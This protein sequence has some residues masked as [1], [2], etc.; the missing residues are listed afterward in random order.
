MLLWYIISIYITRLR[1]SESLKLEQKHAENIKKEN[2]AQ[3]KLFTNISH[4]FRTPL[5]LIISQIET[6]IQNNRF[7]NQTYNKLSIAYHNC[8]QLRELITELLDYRKHEMGHLKLQVCH[9]DIIHFVRENYI[10][11]SDYASKNNI[12]IEFNTD[13]ESLDLW[14]DPKHFQKVINNLLFNAIKSTGNGGKISIEVK[15]DNKNA[16]ISISDNGKG[17][18]AKDIDKIFDI[19]YQV[20]DSNSSIPGTTGSGIGLAF[21]KTIID[22]HHGNIKV[23]SK[24][25]EGSTFSIILPLGKA[26][27]SKSE[28]IFSQPT[29]YS[30]PVFNSPTPIIQSDE[31]ESTT[32]IAEIS[33]KLQSKP[34]MF[35]VE[36]NEQIRAMLKE[37]LS[38]FYYI[39]SF[40]TA[41]SAISE[42]EA[43]M[44]DIVITD[45]MMPGMDGKELCKRIKSNPATSHIPV[46]LLTAQNAIDQY[47]EG[48][49][50][51]ADDYITKPFNTQLLISRCNNLVNSRILLQEKFSHKPETT[52]QM[53][54]SNKIDKEI[55]DKAISIIEANISNTDFNM[56]AFARE[57]GMARTNLFAKIK[58][59][60]GQ[61]PNDFIISI[62]LKKGAY[63]LRNNP[64]LNITEIAEKIGFSSPRYFSKCFKDIYN[65]SPLTYRKG[66]DEK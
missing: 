63:L 10:L 64:E 31:S 55:L 53:L 47:I 18:P 5:T 11:F 1:L 39:R 49:R 8:M 58:A 41:E 66:K 40:A 33:L 25:G 14:F 22:M 46:V 20:E 3:L 16:I 52:V 35:I 60:S 19:F 34:Q 62:R 9:N 36:D 32:E 29:D 26:H 61:T 7:T 42:I 17:I 30:P 15:K 2:Q 23:S 6:L 45:V 50:T 57:M 59:I 43:T 13:Y 24:E 44:P 48:L 21:V 56:N 65:I 37:I 51:G 12:T 4:E 54:A 38:P 28:I 27:F